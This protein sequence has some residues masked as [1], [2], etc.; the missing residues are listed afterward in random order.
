MV[1]AARREDKAGSGALPGLD[2]YRAL[3]VLLVLLFHARIGDPPHA[4]LEVGWIGVQLFFVLSGFLI[5]GLLLR[6]KNQPLGPYLRAFYGRRFLRI[7]PLYYGYISLLLAAVLLT[8]RETPTTSQFLFAATYTYNF[9]HAS[10]HFV[11]SMTMTHLWSLAVEEQF[12]FVWPLVLY[13]CPERWLKRFLVF[14]VVMGPLVR[15]A[16]YFVLKL[17]G[18]VVLGKTALALYVLPITHA[19]A[20]ALGA[21]ASQYSGRPSWRLGAGVVALALVAGLSACIAFPDTA[22]FSSLGYPLA[23]PRGYGY[24]WS[25]TLINLVGAVLI[26]ALINRRFLPWFFESRPMSYLGKISYGFY[27]LHYPLQDVVQRALPHGP[28][29]LRLIVL[30]PLVV[31]VAGASYRWFESPLLKL[32]DRFFPYV[33]RD[34]S[35]I[36]HPAPSVGVGIMTSPGDGASS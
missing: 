1:A 23:M 7:A 8:H 11:P 29:L 33:A 22:P 20:F 31:V 4:F 2:G 21:L 3:A 12:Y 25:Y 15:L 19:D 26:L 9:F 14:L 36:V 24:A 32:K 10:S 13:F 6:S 35:A 18:P 17:L 5:S 34:A 28:F 16:T 27:V 30:V